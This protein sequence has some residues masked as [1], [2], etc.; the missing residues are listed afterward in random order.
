[1]TEQ[2]SQLATR[3]V[4]RSQTRVEVRSLHKHFGSGN[5]VVRALDGIDLTVGSGEMVVLLGPSG[6]GKTTLLRSIAGLERPDDGE[7]YINGRC[8][9]SAANKVFLPPEVRDLG[10]VFQSYAL[11]PHM[12]VRTN[13]AYPLRCRRLP[14]RE[15]GPRV[16]AVLDAVGLTGLG[17]RMPSQLSGGQ[18]QRVSLARAI[19]ANPSVIL[20]DEPLSNVDAKVREQLRREIVRLQNEFGFGAIYVTHDQSEAGAL[21]DQLVIMSAGRIEE[22][23]APEE[24]YAHPHSTYVATFMGAT[25]ELR[26]VLRDADVPSNAMITTRAGEVRGLLVDPSVES[27]DVIAFFRPESC[28]LSDARPDAT[29]NVWRGKLLHR[30][31][32]GTYAELMVE[33]ELPNDENV[34]VIAYSNAAAEWGPDAPIWLHVPPSSVR[35]IHE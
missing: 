3:A 9:Y 15:I 5:A 33:L 23:G 14:K 4:E 12:D 21:A 8:V 28:V 7:I 22:S 35:L 26:G 6:C 17:A 11:W 1:M 13:V 25:N 10:M 16:D 31:F 27:K 20:F 24:L 29:A 18:Q 19:V 32:M 30:M 2:L 34:S